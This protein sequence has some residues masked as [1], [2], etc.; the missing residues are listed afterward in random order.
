[1]ITW[2]INEQC[3]FQCSYCLQKNEKTNSLSLIN[4]SK[5]TESLQFIG[6]DWIFH[7]TGGEPFLER[8]IVDICTEI[9]KKHYLSINTN[10]STNN[11]IEF[12]NKVDPNRTLLINA[13]V[14]ISE[15]EKRDVNL[16]SYIDKILF[17]QKKGFNVIAYYVVH[18]D[19]L[20]RI[21][22][23]VLFLRQNGVKNVRLKAFKGFFEG[24]Y[25]PSSYGID[26]RKLFEVFDIDYPEHRILDESSRYQGLL[27]KAGQK[28][29][30]MDRNGNLRRCTSLYKSY[31]NLF[32]RSQVI[33]PKP[34]PCPIAYCSC[35]Y[36][37][38]RNC[39]F[40]KGS[41]VSILNESFIEYM[42]L[43]KRIIKNPFLLKKVRQRILNHF[44]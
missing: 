38:L 10:L 44:N 14:H 35:H 41:Y 31:G 8:N 30:L 24:R 26:E 37:G 4:I 13:S 9:V 2:L 23:D 34:K 1:M 39:L 22:E 16:V 3:N 5:L 36:E 12:G 29:Y 17:L 25:Y 18:P 15:R 28:F 32:D 7:I 21:T 19:L 11:I 42:F 20:K 43:A 6:S 33:D 27:C 40:L